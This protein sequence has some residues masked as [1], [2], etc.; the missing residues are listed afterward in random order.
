IPR[1]VLL[2]GYPDM[3]NP[4]IRRHRSGQSYLDEEG[5]DY[6]DST[7][8]IEAVNP[9]ERFVTPTGGHYSNEGNKAIAECVANEIRQAISREKP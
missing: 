1:I 8:C 9:N 6:F 5:I 4:E 7:P 3:V 2:A